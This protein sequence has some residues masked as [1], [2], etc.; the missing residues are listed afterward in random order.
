MKVI[1]KAVRLDEAVKVFDIIEQV[2]REQRDT[3]VFV[4]N[5][6][7]EELKRNGSKYHVYLEN[8]PRSFHYHLTPHSGCDVGD[9]TWLA[10]TTGYS[11]AFSE[12]IHKASFIDNCTDCMQ[13]VQF[14]AEGL[15]YAHF[16][17][18]FKQLLFIEVEK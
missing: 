18:A 15:G 14:E 10:H 16:N 11:A 13:L 7:Y 9:E 1:E 6:L 8:F 17:R 3:Q 12:I 4:D 2:L 5:A